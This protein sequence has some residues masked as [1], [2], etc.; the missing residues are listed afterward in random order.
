[1]IRNQKGFT[2]FEIVIVIVALL[3]IGAA[4]YFAYQ[5]RQD[6]TDYSVSVSK[7]K[8][9]KA[10]SPSTTASNSSFL[11]IKEWGVKIPQQPASNILSYQIQGD[12]AD[13]VSSEQ[14]SLGGDCG[15]FYMSRY[16]VKKVNQGY[17]PQDQTEA[18]K[19]NAAPKVT[20]GANVYYIIGDMNG[21]VCNAS[22]Q[23]PGSSIS[24]AEQSANNNLLNSLRGMV[25]N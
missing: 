16:H 21:G 12:T 17:S 9:D 19:L 6:K 15:Q 22:I 23:K 14:K 13:F 2:A 3:A 20:I 18:N 25:A 4:G 5:A 7:K 1:M 24:P 11:V 8:T 10:Q